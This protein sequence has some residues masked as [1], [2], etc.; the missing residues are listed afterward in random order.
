MPGP[1]PGASARHTTV[2]LRHA[3]G[4]STPQRLDS[5]N[6]VPSPLEVTAVSRIRGTQGIQ[7]ETKGHEELG[8]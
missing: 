1:R 5:A 6:H 4:Y 2:R 8:D 7:E 3:T